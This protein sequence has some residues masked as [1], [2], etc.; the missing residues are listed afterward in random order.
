MNFVAGFARR[1]A[2][3][4]SPPASPA[5]NP[6]A[7]GIIRFVLVKFYHA[8]RPERVVFAW[9]NEIRFNGFLGGVICLFLGKKKRTM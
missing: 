3:R 7:A 9:H 4:Q 2:E 1:L 8:G 6:V 5:G